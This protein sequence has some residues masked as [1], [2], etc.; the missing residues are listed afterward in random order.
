[1]VTEKHAR[2]YRN[3]VL[4]QIIEKAGFGVKGISRMLNGIKTTAASGR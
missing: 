4:A 2:G 3:A 1:M